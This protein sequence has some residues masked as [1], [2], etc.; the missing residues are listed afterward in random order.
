MTIPPSEYG[1]KEINMLRDDAVELINKA[2]KEMG[3][4][5]LLKLSL[6]TVKQ[7]KKEFVCDLLYE[8]LGYLEEFTGVVSTD[9]KVASNSVK[10]QVI[11]RQETII[12]LQSDLLACKNEQLESLQTSVKSSVGESVKAEFLSY[13]SAL[14]ANSAEPQKPV[15]TDMIKTVV[16]TVVQEDRSK[17]LI[18]FGLPEQNNEE[19]NKEV[20]EVLQTIG[21]KPRIEACRI[22]RQRSEKNIRPVKVTAA[23]STVISQIL[24]KSRRLRSSEKF[25][26]VFISPDRSPEQRAKQRELVKEIKTL[27]AKQPDKV[28]FIRNG[29]IISTD[30]TNKTVK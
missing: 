17:N 4:E 26:T 24:A 13:S 14:Q 21:E 1:E 12:K 2:T 20:C 22:G 16:Q 15:S 8:A 19:L 10:H 30:G 25:K 6:W 7:M 29:T 5:N 9:Y 11:E 28:H 27:V 3:V 23:S 18:I